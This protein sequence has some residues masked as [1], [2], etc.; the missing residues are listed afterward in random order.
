MLRM[1]IVRH[2][3]ALGQSV[4]AQR[5][6]VLHALRIGRHVHHGI[7]LIV[8]ALGAEQIKLAVHAGFGELQQL[9]QIKD[10]TIQMGH[11]TLVCASAGLQIEANN[12][13]RCGRLAARMEGH[14]TVERLLRDA[15][16]LYGA[17]LE[18][19]L[20]CWEYFLD[21]FVYTHI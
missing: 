13:E 4:L 12:F 19:C 11:H 1:H 6:H 3:N 10:G 21:T 16:S 9:I 15:G 20:W 18:V 14:R 17:L 2:H 5:H 7:Q 8:R